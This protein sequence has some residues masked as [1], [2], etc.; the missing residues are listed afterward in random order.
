LLEKIPIKIYTGGVIVIE[1][2][3]N[4][5]LEPLNFILDTGSGGIS[6]DSAT[7]AEFNIA[8][9][10]TDTLVSG[11]GGTR[12]VSYA[13]NQTL[14]T[15]KLKTDNLNFYVNDYSLLSSVYGEKIDGIIGFGLLSRYIFEINF[16]SSYIKIYSPG[17]YKYEVGGTMIYPTFS[18]L[19]AHSI[20]IKDKI[21]TNP[22]IYFDTGAG[23]CLLLTENF[24]KDNKI[25]LSRRKPVIT[26]VQGLNGKKKMRLTVVK[27]VQIGP[28]V[29]RN[30]P[31]NL[32]DDAENVTSY[33]YTAGLLGND[34]LRRFNIVLNYPSKEIH[35]KPNGSFYDH[36]DYAYTGMTLYSYGDKIIID[37]IVAKSPAEKAGLKNGD[38]VICVSNDCSGKILA[39]ENLL[40]KAR[41]SV[42]LIISRNGKVLFITLFPL[43]IR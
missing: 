22:N 21:K 32:Y 2:K 10:K 24:L 33:P 26:E 18:R 37:D 8:S 31:T 43:S 5:I 7:C 38:E 11:I 28:Y 36:F 3:L 35:L 41:E 16:D 14:A 15:G 40:Q 6:L 17:K 29:F 4:N 27:R 13:F 19:I 34:I 30:V 23:L 9:R 20:G 1:A 12:N 25:L 39:Y 42:K